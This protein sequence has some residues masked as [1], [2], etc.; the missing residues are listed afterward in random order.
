[1]KRRCSLSKRDI[2]FLLSCGVFLLM[3]LGAIG[4]TGRRRAKEAVCLSNLRQWGTMFDSYTIDHNGYFQ[5]GFSGVYG[6]GNNRW[7]KALGDYHK[8]DTDFSCCPEAIMP[9]FD[10]NGNDTGRVGTHLGSTTA[11][12][13]YQR[14]GWKK[15]FKGSYGINGWVNNPA[16][17]EGHS[18]KPEQWHWR[19][20]HVQGAAYVP[21][22]IGAQRYNQWP[23]QHDSPP[24]YDGQFWSGN[25]H[26]ARICLN[27]HNG[28]V[29]CLFMDFSARKVGLKEL[30]KLKWHRQFDTNGPWTLAG[31]ATTADW[32]QWMRD[33]EDH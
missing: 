7:V 11:W 17:G 28:A 32:P 6:G 8:W 12:G 30:W 21:L 22:L 1:M 16:P 9:W 10:E 29:N 3:N 24:L 25:D 19:T 13:Y 2:V 20:P 23:E 18:G 27:R 26:L 31:G 5:E 15:P 14:A 4:S 33:F